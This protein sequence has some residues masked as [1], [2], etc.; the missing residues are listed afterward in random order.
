MIYMRRIYR[1]KKIAGEVPDC[2]VFLLGKAELIK[3]R[4]QGN[5][6]LLSDYNPEERFLFKRFLRDVI[7]E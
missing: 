7:W 3:I 4:K 6:N 5:E 1:M 2:M